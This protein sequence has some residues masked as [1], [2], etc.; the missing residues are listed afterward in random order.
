MILGRAWNT[1]TAK[2]VVEPAKLSTLGH[3]QVFA[4]DAAADEGAE[5]SMIA[6]QNNYRLTPAPRKVID[7]VLREEP[8]L[9]AGLARLVVGALLSSGDVSTEGLLIG[10]DPRARPAVYPAL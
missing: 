2:A 5:I 8:R 3:V 6:P 7:T 9:A 10:I 4:E 1:A